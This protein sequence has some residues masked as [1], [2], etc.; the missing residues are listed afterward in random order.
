M[1][2]LIV[3]GLSSEGSAVKRNFEKWRQQTFLITRWLRRKI[4]ICRFGKREICGRLE[5]LFSLPPTF[6]IFSCCARTITLRFFYPYTPRR[7]YS[8]F[9]S[10][11][12][13]DRQTVSPQ[14]DTICHV[15]QKREKLISAAAANHPW[16]GDPFW[17]RRIRVLRMLLTTFPDDRSVFLSSIW[18]ITFTTFLN[19]DR[20][21][22]NAKNT[23]THPGKKKKW[24]CVS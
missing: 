2:G 15:A 20:Q 19:L 18:E 8:R 16:R 14:G 9:L 13:C 7:S 12:S 23:K 24:F 21:L 1:A 17:C 5:D 10:L 22:T 11:L 3:G 4:L 6:A